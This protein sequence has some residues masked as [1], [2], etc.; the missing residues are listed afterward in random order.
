MDGS[1]P[2]SGLRKVGLSLFFCCGVPVVIELGTVWLLMVALN[3]NPGPEYLS[4]AIHLQSFT[5]KGMSTAEGQAAFDLSPGK[6]KIWAEFTT[7]IKGKARHRMIIFRFDEGKVYR[8]DPEKK[9]YAERPLKDGHRMLEQIRDI[10]LGG[11]DGK[12]RAQPVPPREGVTDSR[13][14]KQVEHGNFTTIFY[15]DGKLDDAVTRVDVSSNKDNF[16]V[17]CK[18]EGAKI[19]PIPESRFEVPEGYTKK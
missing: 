9:T 13:V 3:Q 2:V 7:R 19:E 10:Y 18:L 1:H 6:E 8:L 12:K 4:G 17:V 16:A 14:C 11:S 15:I 5:V